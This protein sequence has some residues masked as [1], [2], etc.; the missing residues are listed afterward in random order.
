MA[1]TRRA[2][3]RDRQG[4]GRTENAL[5]VVVVLTVIGAG[6]FL[7]SGDLLRG[8]EKIG[9]YVTGLFGAP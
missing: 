8:M 6:S 9:R 1:R 4:R 2:G 5:I 7:F 3:S